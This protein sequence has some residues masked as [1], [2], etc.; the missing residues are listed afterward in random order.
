M[1]IEDCKL[2]IEA[3]MRNLLGFKRQI[4]LTMEGDLKVLDLELQPVYPN[5]KQS[6][7]E[8]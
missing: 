4:F 5:V 7:V 6:C 1:E 2:E 3:L 8:N